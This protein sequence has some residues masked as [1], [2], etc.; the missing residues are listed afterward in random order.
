V[1]PTQAAV[2][3]PVVDVLEPLNAAIAAANARV[4]RRAAA[5]PVP[6]RLT[7]APGVGPV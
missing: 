5:D 2:V 1:P 3:A 7:T 6:R 4:A